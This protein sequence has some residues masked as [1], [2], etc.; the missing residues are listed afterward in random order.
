MPP[1]RKPAVPSS[2]RTGL[3]SA[4]PTPP[5]RWAGECTLLALPADDLAASA[6][7]EAGVSTLVDA[8][9]TAVRERLT[10][11]HTQRRADRENVQAERDAVAGERDGVAAQRDLPPPAPYT[12]AASRDGRAGAPLWRLVSFAEQVPDGDRARIEA[13]LETAGLL[14]AWMLPDGS[15]T[16][17]LADTFADAALGV[18][19]PGGSLADVLI[20]EPDAPVAAE[21]VTRL[22]TAVAY[23][24]IAHGSGAPDHSA[25]IGVDGSWR[26]GVAHGAMTKPEPAYIGATARDRAR[27]RR[28][29]ELDEQLA[30]LDE[31]LAELDA[32]LAAIVQQRA[33]LSAELTGRPGHGEVRAAAARRD[34]ADAAV[35]AR[36]DA[37]ASS[38]AEVT[39]LAGEARTADTTVHQRAAE[40]ALPATESGLA[41]HRDALAGLDTAATTWLDERTTAAGSLREAELR[42]AQA[43]RSAGLVEEATER[44]RE[45][46]VTAQQLAARLAAVEA[47]VGVEFRELDAQLRV[48]TDRIGTIDIERE[49]LRRRENELGERIGELR[50]QSE[51]DDADRT[52][53]VADRDAAAEVLRRL[54]AGT[55]GADAQLDVELADGVTAMLAAA[56][57]VAEQVRDPFEE[58]H[59]RAAQ[60]RLAETV[61]EVR[62]LLAGRADLQTEQGNDAVLLTA[63]VDGRPVAAA[64]LHR[65]LAGEHAAAAEALTDEERDLFDRTLTGDTRRHVAERIRTADDLVRSMNRKLGRVRTASR[66]RVQLSWQVDPELPPGTRAARDL[67]LRDPATLT[68]G[69]RD[70]LH[71]FFRERITEAR[72]AGEAASWEAQLTQVFDY[73]AWH[74]FLVTVDL[75]DDGGQRQVT[76]KLHGTMSGGE[77]AIV[78]HLPLF[79]AIAVHYEACPTAPRLVLLDEVFVGIDPSNRGQLL[80]LVR[81]FDLDAVLTSDHEWC[82]YAELDGIAIHQLLTDETDRAVTTARFV[83]DG[84]ALEQADLPE[85]EPETPESEVPES[86][87]EPAAPSLFDG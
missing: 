39:R 72:D 33:E 82:T 75:G 87:P 47:S 42:A 9:A 61:H 45:L 55:L 69:E 30:A 50:A 34:R 77:K 41:D 71:R 17:S 35:A 20:V 46:D 24:P 58:R 62:E 81:G 80:D 23:G 21:H 36:A 66:V 73:T 28:L 15:L 2:R 60:G 14:D 79:A 3:A 12:R 65:L 85:P 56:R 40:L 37:V 38:E 48:I 4:P 63:T 54:A 26:L 52:A 29:A 44:A 64:A 22:L 74:R 10:A 43:Q 7:D 1:G 51:R 13:A 19:A 11:A 5:R 84:I 83:W 53:A 68:A 31:R 70:A 67:L 27:A 25:V 16:G 86:Q 8:A 57:A 49:R 59:L 76:R 32:A 18:P 78:L 6:A